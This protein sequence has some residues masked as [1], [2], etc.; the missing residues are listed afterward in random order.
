MSELSNLTDEDREYVLGYEAT[1]KSGGPMF[2]FPG[3][4]QGI[5]LCRI[6]RR[7]DAALTEAQRETL[8]RFRRRVLEGEKP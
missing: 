8:E 3:T 7:L 6:I 5:E 2:Q 4:G 1:T